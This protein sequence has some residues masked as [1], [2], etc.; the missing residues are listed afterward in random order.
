MKHS[1]GQKIVI[2]GAVVLLLAYGSYGQ[3]LTHFK[4]K[5]VTFHGNLSATGI[6]YRS[7]GIMARK[8]P[9]TYILS[10]NFTLNVKGLALPFSFTYS[11]RNFNFRQPFNRFGISPKYK[12]ITLHLGYRN[13]SFSRYVLGGHTVLG[14]GVELTPG[15]FR[16]GAVYGRLRRRTNQATKIYEP[17]T[18]TLTSFTRKIISIKVGVGNAKN[19]F[20]VIVLRA[21][22]D[23][24]SVDPSIKE[25]G[26][27]PEANFVTGINSHFTFWRNIRF[28]LE[29]AYSIYTDN[30]NTVLTGDVPDILTKIIPVNVTT[31][32]SYALRSLLEYRSEKGLIFGLKYRRIA[33]EYQSMGTYFINNDLE[34]ITFHTGFRALKQKLHF[35]GSIGLER[36]NLQTARNATT[37]KLIGSAMLS[38]N[39]FRQFGITLNYSNYSINQQPGRVQIADS[40]KLYQTNGTLVV[41]PHLQ[42]TGKNNKT[43]HFI[44]LVFTRMNLDDKNSYTSSIN[45]FSTTNYIFTYNITFVETGWSAIVTLNSNKVELSTGN[46]NNSGAT[47]GMNKRFFKSKITTGITATVSQNKNDLQTLLVFNYGFTGQAR[48]GKHHRIRIR[49]NFISKKDKALNNLQTNEQI[50]DLSYVYAF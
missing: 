8:P 40:V 44:S 16:F 48:L 39:P 36:N 1:F 20:D 26:K 41:M 13:I 38:Y 45:S 23:S 24:T 32:G 42:L 29:G 5:R 4:E 9:F 11:D 15:L 27:F 34:N 35:N 50:G 22:D 17:L 30:Q 10:G 47:L 43:A 28:E 3:D 18:D 12:W 25:I 49:L 7:V 6:F 19:F 14:A 31:H 46:S 37:K 2:I 21:A 33:P